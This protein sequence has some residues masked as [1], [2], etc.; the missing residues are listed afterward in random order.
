MQRLKGFPKDG[1]SGM[2]LEGCIGE[3]QEVAAADRG[4]HKPGGQARKAAAWGGVG[5][6]LLSLGQ[7]SRGPV[8]AQVLPGDQVCSAPYLV[9]WS[10]PPN[11]LPSLLCR[12]GPI[13]TSHSTPPSSTF[14]EPPEPAL[15]NRQQK[16]PPRPSPHNAGPVNCRV[17][18]SLG[19]WQDACS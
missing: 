3:H 13:P 8:A 4:N 2:G 16:G 1:L 5:L 14:E 12:S 17:G 6:E 11:S 10:R 7:L 18:R 15:I 19:R 9:A